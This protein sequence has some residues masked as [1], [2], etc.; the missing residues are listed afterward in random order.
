M[1]GEK[2]LRIDNPKVMAFY[3]GWYGVPNNRHGW[4][5]WNYNEG[6]VECSQ[7]PDQDIKLPHYPSAGF[8]NSNDDQVMN[9]HLAFAGEAGLDALIV[10]WWGAGSRFNKLFPRMLDLAKEYSVKLTPYYES[11]LAPANIYFLVEDFISILDGYSSHESFLKINGMPVI[12]VYDRAIQQ[13]S[14]KEWQRAIELLKKRFGV[15]LIADTSSRRLGA[16]FDGLH[17]YSPVKA[18]KRWCCMDKYY[19]QYVDICRRLDKI[20]CVTVVPGFDDTGNGARKSWKCRLHQ[21]LSGGRPYVLE[22]NGGQTYESLWKS[23]I[24]ATPDWILVTSFNEWIE[25]TEIE[26]SLEFGNQY[27]SLTRRYVAEFKFGKT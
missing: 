12:F 26:P 16:Y 22:R 23:A 8:Y 1:C 2:S 4:H 21:F 20:A 18:M 11:S 13:Y 10:S 7:V 27:I 17:F 6:G 25:G 19:R 3:Y 5:M 14:R 15:L 24:R 9:R